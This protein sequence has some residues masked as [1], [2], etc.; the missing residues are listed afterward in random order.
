MGYKFAVYFRKVVP[1]RLHWVSTCRIMKVLSRAPPWLLGIALGLV[2]SPAAAWVETRVISDDVVVEVERSGMATIDHGIRMQV[3]GGPL[4]SFD[5][6]VVE[7]D[8]A[9]TDGSAV[10]SQP[11][12]FV[13]VPISLHVTPGP[14]GALRVNVDSPRGISRG[15]F[16]FHVRYRKNLLARG[17]VRRDG[18]MLRIAWTGPAWPAGL[19]NAK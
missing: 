16:L 19:D 7:A 12:G 10:A 13:G 2:A 14:D 6:P 8:I 11:E 18:A 4:R 5:L 1:L 3:K 15:T 9:P 17:N